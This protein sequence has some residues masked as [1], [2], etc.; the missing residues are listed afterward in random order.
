[1]KYDTSNKLHLIVDHIPSDRVTACKPSIFPYCII[2][3]NCYKISF[4]TEFPIRI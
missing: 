4:C 2:A 1:M 3:L